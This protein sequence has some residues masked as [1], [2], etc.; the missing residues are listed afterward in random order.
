MQIWLRSFRQR[1]VSLLSASVTAMLF[2]TT[3]NTP[4]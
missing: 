1:P 2:I 4:C 3:L